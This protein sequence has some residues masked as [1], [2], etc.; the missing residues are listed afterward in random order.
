M[1]DVNAILEAGKQI[2]A[3]SA[4][5]I[6][7]NGVPLVLVPNGMRLEL[8]KG[9]LDLAEQNAP[10]PRDV[11]GVATLVHPDS[12]IA[13]VNR[14]KGEGS[15]LWADP[16]TV[17]MV[18]VYDY[19][20][21]PKDPRWKRHRAIYTCP[22]SQPWTEWSEHNC[23]A[24]G[25]EE[26]GDFIDEH[27]QDIASQKKEYPEAA[28]VLEMARDLRIH[29]KGVFERQINPTTGESHMLVKDEHDSTSTK[30]HRA[31]LLQ[32]PVFDGGDL[33]AVEAR[34]HFRMSSG[35]PVFSYE[36]QRVD[37]ILRHA[38]DEVVS[39]ACTATGLPAFYGK[40]EV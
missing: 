24:M 18:A 19:P 22:L 7:I 4:E 36:M 39:K 15:A 27:A 3:N 10:T 17:Q 25:Q 32:L 11:S 2:T 34:V 33:Y 16:A 30:I 31:F 13:H 20:P 37:A 23:E 21:G 1:I 14:F 38:F 28:A 9:A 8:P 5:P 12:F 35:R 6:N 26:F 40:P 29:I